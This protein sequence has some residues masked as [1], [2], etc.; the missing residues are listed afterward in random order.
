M[1]V[2]LEPFPEWRVHISNGLWRSIHFMGSGEVYIE[3]YYIRVNYKKMMQNIDNDVCVCVCVCVCVY[4][5]LYRIGRKVH[6]HAHTHIH[7]H[8]CPHTHT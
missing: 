5:S 4:F 1:C 2:T 6:T 7:R 8:T 3:S